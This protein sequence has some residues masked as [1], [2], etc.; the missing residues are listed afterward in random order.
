MGTVLHE[1]MH[2][3]G[4]WHEQARADRDNYIQIL[5][6][7]I[8]P[9]MTRNFEKKTLGAMTHLGAQ[10]DYCSVMHYGSNDF[11]MNGKPTIIKKQESACELGEQHDLSTIDVR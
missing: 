10:Y 9:N 1:Y 11:S 4:F 7:N 6:D 3:A 8:N 5:W 2:A